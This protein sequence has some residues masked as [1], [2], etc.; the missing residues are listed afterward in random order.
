MQ[1]C[2]APQGEGLLIPFLIPAQLCLS[3]HL[4]HKKGFEKDVTKFTLGEACSRDGEG[5]VP[6]MKEK[7]LDPRTCSQN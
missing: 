7:L 3:W 4:I 2:A 6:G 5:I 1:R